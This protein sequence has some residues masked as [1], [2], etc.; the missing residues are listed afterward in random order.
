ML[1]LLGAPE[2]TYHDQALKFAT[3]KALAL[4][5]YLVVERGLHPRDK[6]VAL[7]WPEGETRLAQAALRNTLARIKAALPGVDAPLRVEGDRVGFNA[8]IAFTPDLELI[9]QATSASVPAITLLQSAAEA[10]RGS[11][12]DGFSLPNAPAF[13]EWL[14]IQRATWGQRQNLVYDRLSLHQLETHLIRPALET[15]IRWIMLDR[16]NEIAYQRLMR[17][18]FL[19]GARSAALQ[20]YETCRDLLAH[21]LGVQPA[22]ETEAILAHIR[23]SPT[24]APVAHVHTELREP[25]HI[26]FVGRSNEY[27][28]LVQS[29]RRAKKGQPQVVVVSGESGI[30]KTR[31]ADEFLKWAS[32]EGADVLRGRAFET[33]GRLPYQPIID[34]LRERLERENAP[35]DLLDDAW[36]V[37]LTRI[38]PELRERYP[39]L[40][41]ATGDESTA[42]ARLSEAIARLAQALAARRPVVWLIDDLQWADTE[43]LDLLRYLSRNWRTSRAPILH[44]VAHDRIREVVYAQLSQARQQIFHRRALAAL[45]EAKASPAELAHHALSA[46]EWQFAFHHSLRA[47]DAAMR[48]YAVAGAAHHYEHARA[49]LNAKK[50]DVIQSHASICIRAL[51]MLTNWNFITARH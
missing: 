24:P 39:D 16:L 41:L 38:L 12:M 15:I 32:T 37:E 18:H 7:F 30:G 10:S 23:S 4:F 33:S 45:A 13:D 14:T 34:A 2:V 11:F 27:Q 44:T 5:A 6:L 49:L 3:R 22:S 48:L 31:L 42:R 9:T 29:F 17:L 40:A 8:S 36:L 43:T 28:G 25:L 20:A 35:A 47:G 26:P 46:K 19:N 1:K 50:A 51:G 21:E